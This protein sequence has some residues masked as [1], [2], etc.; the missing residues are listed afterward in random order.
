MDEMHR[1][2]AQYI[3]NQFDSTMGRKQLIASA[4]VQAKYDGIKVLE[5]FLTRSHGLLKREKDSFK[6][7]TYQ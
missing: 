6:Y 1:W 4:F 2:N 7:N 3:G 5:S